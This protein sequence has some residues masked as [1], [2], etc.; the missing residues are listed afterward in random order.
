MGWFL[1]DEADDGAHE[2]YL[3]AVALAPNGWEW[4]ELGPE[5]S[6]GSTTGRTTVTTVRVACDCGWRS[7]RIVCP[8]GVYYSPHVVVV[9]DDLDAWETACSELWKEHA[10]T[11]RARTGCPL[12]WRS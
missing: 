12:T 11:E 1:G 10:L 2:G 4:R 9:P 8:P 3:C 6:D 7:R 5:L